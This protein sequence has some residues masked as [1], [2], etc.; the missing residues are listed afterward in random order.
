MKCLKC[1]HDNPATIQYCQKCGVKL[2]MTAD[3]I[4][5]AL[6]EKAQGERRVTTEH[7]A[8]Q[9]LFF[10]GMLFVLSLTLFLLSGGAPEEVH[11]IP[12]AAGGSKYVEIGWR[13]DPPFERALVPLKK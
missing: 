6:V 4:G 3:E 8:K 2:D 10:A 7:Y 12:S 13:F 5:A 11:A 9:S 1:R